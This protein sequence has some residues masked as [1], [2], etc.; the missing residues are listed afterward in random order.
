MLQLWTNIVQYCAYLW[1]FMFKIG[2]T[3]ITYKYESNNENVAF[4]SK[5]VL[6]IENIA[7]ILAVTFFKFTVQSNFLR[8][9]DISLCIF[10]MQIPKIDYC[11]Y[12]GPL[13]V[14]HSSY[15]NDE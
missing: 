9:I 11:S 14:F 8:S 1:L 3:K 2:I 6:R 13:L 5:Y 12:I 15:F 4:N 7:V 10:Y